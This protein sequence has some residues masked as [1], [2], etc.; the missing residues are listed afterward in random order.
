MLRISI[1]LRTTQG[2]FIFLCSLKK[3]SFCNYYLTP[4]KY[5]LFTL[6]PSINKKFAVYEKNPQ[7]IEKNINL[8]K[9]H[10]Y[11][12]G[13]K[14]DYKTYGQ[15]SDIKIEKLPAQIG[16]TYLHQSSLHQP[17][18]TKKIDIFNHDSH[19]RFF[20]IIQTPANSHQINNFHFILCRLQTHKNTIIYCK[21]N[22]QLQN[23]FGFPELTTSDTQC[24]PFEYLNKH[25]L[26]NFHI[27]YCHF[28]NK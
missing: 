19:P 8:E 23:N 13:I 15:R 26:L 9:S 7:L 11:Y 18:E 5:T 20:H 17:F 22:T 28:S 1:F 2:K 27:N 12:Y 16:F 4:G 25:H 21:Y 6:L 3:D 14:Q 24:P 10:I